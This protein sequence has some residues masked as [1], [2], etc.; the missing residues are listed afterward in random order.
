MAEPIFKRLALIGI[1]LIGSSVARIDV[2]SLPP[3][4]VARISAVP[5]LILASGQ[6][7]VGTKAFEWLKQFDGNTEVESF[8]LGKGLP[9][10]DLQDDHF[11]MEF[12]TPYSAFEPVP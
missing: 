9:F 11:A 7:L 12:T 2:N 3:D 10:S 6:M 4:Q 5:T 1:G 8:C